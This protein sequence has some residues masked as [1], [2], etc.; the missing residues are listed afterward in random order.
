MRTTPHKPGAIRLIEATIGERLEFYSDRSGGSDACWPW[1][2]KIAI[3][4][5]G[6]VCVNQKWR[7]AHRISYE[8]AV[9]PI[10]EGLT[11]DHLC[12]NRLCVNPA[13]LEAVT[14]AEN[15]RRGAKAQQTHCIRGHEFT[16]RNTYIKANGTR[17]CRACN[18]KRIR[19][20]RQAAR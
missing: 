11:I 9:G 13:H 17:S 1:T 20:K 16:E 19:E 8:W 18:A 15:V 2:G 3:G 5:Y 6:A 4:G 7:K 12:R 14:H 10:P